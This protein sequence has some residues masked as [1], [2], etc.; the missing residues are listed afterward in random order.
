MDH[1]LGG[2]AGERDNGDRALGYRLDLG[3][4][5][6]AAADRKIRFQHG[7]NDF[8]YSSLR[9]TGLFHFLQIE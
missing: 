5:T 6:R 3:W 7:L 2:C 9:I 1:E 8:P 4:D